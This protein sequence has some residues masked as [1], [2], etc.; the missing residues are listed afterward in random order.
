MVLRYTN[1]RRLMQ[2]EVCTLYCGTA[3]AANALG[4]TAPGTLVVKG[5]IIGREMVDEFFPENDR[6]P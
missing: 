6:S 3:P 2:F 1:K 5:G 4:Y